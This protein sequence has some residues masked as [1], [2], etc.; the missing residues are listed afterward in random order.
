MYVG[1]NP[2]RLVPPWENK[3]IILQ[4]IYMMSPIIFY[5]TGT[6]PETHPKAKMDEYPINRTC[7]PMCP[8]AIHPILLPNS[9]FNGRVNYH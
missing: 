2:R 4:Y 3:F 5:P 1:P 7:H 6:A 9:Q 8:T